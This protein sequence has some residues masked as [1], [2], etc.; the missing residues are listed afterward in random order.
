MDERE[1]RMELEKSLRT[2]MTESEWLYLLEGG[3]WSDY[4]EMDWSEFWELVRDKLKGL[5]RFL[6][7][8]RRESAG[9]MP[10]SNGESARRPEQPPKPTI[11]AGTVSGRTKARAAAIAASDWLRRGP[12]AWGGPSPWKQP[13]LARKIIEPHIE[14]VAYTDGRPPRWVVRL[15]VEAWVPAEDVRRVYEEQQSKL[16]ADTSPPKTQ[17]LTYDVARF[18][19]G[20]ELMHGGR[21]P[22]R[23]LCEWWNEHHP[24]QQIKDYRVFRTYCERGREATLPK[25]AH[26]DEEIVSM[27]RELR[28]WRANPPSFGLHAP[29]PPA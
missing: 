22:W 5:R 19:W 12:N 18:V 29:P 25:Y 21:P 26:T 6:A 7:N 28:E 27:A 9:E 3:L 16:L 2:R 20:Q 13:H 14:P 24:D 10:T 17:A 1:L 4:A 23:K 15:R 11:S 8:A